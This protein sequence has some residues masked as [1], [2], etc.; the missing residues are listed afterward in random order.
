[1]ANPYHDELGRFTTKRGAVTATEIANGLA[2]VQAKKAQSHLVSGTAL[3]SVRETGGVTINLK[4]EKP[5]EGYAFAPRKD[6]ERIIPAAQL[7]LKDIDA[8]INDRL[9]DL[10]KKGAHLGMW[11]QDGDVYI[12]VSQ[13][14]PASA[15]TIAKAQAAQ[16]LAVFD[17]ATF[18]EI[19][20]GNILNG[21]YRK[22]DDPSSIQDRYLDGPQGRSA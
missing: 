3:K 20:I 19:N 21:R 6:T 18:E 9:D 7:K 11:T 15:Q 14:G 16:Q 10:T 2:A 17:L 12:D 1:M 5:T 13:V 22:L 4:G 8:F